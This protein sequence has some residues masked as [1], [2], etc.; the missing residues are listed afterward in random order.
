MRER[1]GEKEGAGERW[2][3]ERGRGESREGGRERERV[4]SSLIPQTFEALGVRVNFQRHGVYNREGMWMRWES[5]KL[6]VLG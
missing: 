6:L 5:G 2:G 1:E 3:G 4:H